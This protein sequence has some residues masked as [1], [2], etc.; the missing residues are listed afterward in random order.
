MVRSPPSS[1][2]KLKKRCIRE[3]FEA[4]SI[5]TGICG[6]SFLNPFI[7]SECGVQK[8]DVYS[9]T[10]ELMIV[11]LRRKPNMLQEALNSPVI[12]LYSLLS[13]TNFEGY[14][15]NRFSTQGALTLWYPTRVYLPRR[16]V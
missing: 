14:A 3:L 6:I 1:G 5:F 13:S 7:R 9:Y 8:D 11:P 12:A 4:F 10:A 16:S 2:I 15:F